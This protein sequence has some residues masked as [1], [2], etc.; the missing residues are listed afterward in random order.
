[1]HRCHAIVSLHRRS[2]SS[3]ISPARLG[4]FHGKSLGGKHKMESPKIH[5]MLMYTEK[6]GIP[7]WW[8]FRSMSPTPQSAWD[9][10]RKTKMWTKNTDC[11]TV[12]LQKTLYRT[13][14][15]IFFKLLVPTSTD[16]RWRSS[17]K[18]TWPQYEKRT[19][20]TTWNH[21]FHLQRQSRGP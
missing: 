1:M 14:Y 2:A 5:H 12:E 10:P 6:E 8:T 3:S 9:V 7:G 15:E 13:W 18:S 4:N 20:P 19:N 11:I 21:I 16:H 17:K